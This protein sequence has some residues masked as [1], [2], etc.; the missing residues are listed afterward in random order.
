MLPFGE[1]SDCSFGAPVGVS[2]ASFF[3]LVFCSYLENIMLNTSLQGKFRLLGRNRACPGRM[4][5]QT[6]YIFKSLG[7][8]CERGND[9][10]DS[11]GGYYY[12]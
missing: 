1:R 7:N 5:Y 6:A 3:Q 8:Y 12:R 9:H 10:G 2:P 11:K 4:M